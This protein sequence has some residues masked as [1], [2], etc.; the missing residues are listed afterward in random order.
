LGIE[1][2]VYGG[3]DWMWVFGWLN[4]S[5]LLLFREIEAETWLKM[6]FSK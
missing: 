1:A 4:P 5:S 6:A 2:A 3:R